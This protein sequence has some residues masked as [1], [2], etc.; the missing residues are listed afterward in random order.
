[1]NN[2]YTAKPNLIF[3]KQWDVSGVNGYITTVIADSKTEAIKKTI[4]SR[5]IKCG[6]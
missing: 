6:R 4:E 1:M 5:P 2:G 3:P